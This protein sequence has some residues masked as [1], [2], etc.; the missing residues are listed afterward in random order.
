MGDLFV[1]SYAHGYFSTE[2]G[3]GCRVIEAFE[4]ERELGDHWLEGSG[5]TRG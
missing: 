3:L 4:E 1:L 5:A 2:V